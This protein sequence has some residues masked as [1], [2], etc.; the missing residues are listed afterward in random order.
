MYNKYDID[1]VSAQGGCKGQNKYKNIE[2]I[3]I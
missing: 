1:N 3:K 2:I